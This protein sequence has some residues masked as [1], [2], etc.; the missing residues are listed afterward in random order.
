MSLHRVLKI[1]FYCQWWIA[2]W[3]GWVPYVKALYYMNTAPFTQASPPRVYKDLKLTWTRVDLQMSCYFC[4]PFSFN[5]VHPDLLDLR[6]M[7]GNEPLRG[8][9]W[10]ERGASTGMKYGARWSGPFIMLRGHTGEGAPR[11]ESW[12][13]LEERVGECVNMCV[14]T[15]TLR[16]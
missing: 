9:T 2:F 7:G 12:E 3:S 11:E 14:Y 10:W 1:T 13:Q 15:F 6:W 5:Q 4:S 16:F 8:L